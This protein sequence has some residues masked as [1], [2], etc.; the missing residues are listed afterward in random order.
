MSDT[1]AAASSNEQL[2]YDIPEAGAMAGLGRNASYTAAKRGQIP[3]ITLGRRKRVP[4][5]RWHKILN[6]DEA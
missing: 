4:A 1:L 2:T 3:T 6:G 5:K